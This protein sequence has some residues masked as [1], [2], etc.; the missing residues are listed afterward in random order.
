MSR[1][2][3]AVLT[4]ATFCGVLFFYGLDGELW[5]TEGLRA[6]VAAEGLRDGNWL[7]PHLY[8][9]PLFTKPPGMYVAVSLVSWP[10]GE[11][12]AWTAR[13]PS[14]LAATATVFLIF[15]LFRHTLG[16]R[17]GFVAAAILPVSVVWLD[18]APSAEIDMLQVFWVTAAIVAFLRALEAEESGS[19]RFGWWALA[20]FSVAGGVLTKWTAPAFFYCTVLPL[21]WWRGGLR[22]LVGGRHLLSAALAAGLCLGWG[23][24]AAQSSGW[25]AFTAAVK[26]EAVQHLSPGHRAEALAQ[27]NESHHVHLGYWRETSLHPLIVLAMTLPWSAFTLLTLR[28]G[29]ASLWDERGRRLLQALH[30]WAWPNLL[31]WSFV[32]QHS[33]RHSLPLFPAIAG[34]AALVWVAWADGRLRRS[35]HPPLNQKRLA[36][37][38]LSSILLAWLG[39][40]LAFVHAIVPQRTA[41]REPRSRGESLAA[42]VPPGQTL[43]LCRVKDEGIMF[44]YGRPVRRLA[45]W[46]E[47]PSFSEHAYCILD[48]AE[49]ERWSRSRPAEVLR[50]LTDEQGAALVLVCVGK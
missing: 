13:L 26:Q 29:F 20:M 2:W 43:Y 41:E 36:G 10:L 1:T 3:P 16:T 50:Q 23:A 38:L 47:L 32:P 25:A 14:A 44:Y 12:R 35:K 30:C 45:G 17:A 19:G 4:L 28:P 6:L 40:K 49:W 48:K 11:V 34:L 27:M 7:V 9:Q 8:G 24:L 46:D 37:F 42:L 18:K 31:F 22:L 39:V 5:R 21:L 15:G 33:P